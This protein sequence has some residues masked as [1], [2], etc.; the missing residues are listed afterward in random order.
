MDSTVNPSGP[1]APNPVGYSLLGNHGSSSQ[2]NNWGWAA[3]N[4]L[5]VLQWGP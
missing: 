4:G 3:G 5:I 1:N 2:N